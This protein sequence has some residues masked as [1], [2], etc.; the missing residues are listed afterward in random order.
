[1]NQN[2][3]RDFVEDRNLQEEQVVRVLRRCRVDVGISVGNGII[4]ME[5]TRH[6]EDMKRMPIDV[7]VH[8]QLDKRRA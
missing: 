2:H 7:Q 3:P 1:M 6:V 8:H 4:N 5:E